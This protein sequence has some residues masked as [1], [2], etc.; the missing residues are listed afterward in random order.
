MQVDSP[1][2]ALETEDQVPRAE[3]IDPIKTCPIRDDTHMRAHN[4]SKGH[5]FTPALKE[6]R[7]TR[8]ERLLQWH[9][10]NR[11]KNIR[12]TDKKFFT[13]EEPYNSQNNNIYAQMSLPTSWFG[14]RCPIWM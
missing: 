11:H 12:F 14:G 3:H 13:I 7:Q 1:K 8:A 6:I 5:L 4:H 2:S 9:A 10:Q